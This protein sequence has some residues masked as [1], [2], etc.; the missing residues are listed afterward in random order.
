MIS[1]S[2][3][4]GSRLWSGLQR[5]LRLRDVMIFS[6][7]PLFV[8]LYLVA[9]AILDYSSIHQFDDSW[10]RPEKLNTYFFGRISAALDLPKMFALQRDLNPEK[11]DSGIIRLSVPSE[12]WNSWQRDPLALMGEWSKA[13]L[14]RHNGLIPVKLRKRGDNSVHWVTEKKS[15]TLRTPAS[16]LFKGERRLA[17]SG[18]TVLHSFSANALASEF[19]LLAPYTVVAPVFVNEK[20]YGVFR[21]LELIDESFLRRNNRLPGNIFRGDAAERGE[22][23]KG[24]PRGLVENPYIWDRV[25]KD[26]LPSAHADETLKTFLSDANGSTFADHLRFMSW[27]D[28]EE[29]SR[30][31]A[32]MLVV[33]DP[34]H[35]SAIHNNYWYQDPSTG[36]LHP[37]PWDLRM[38]I[39]EVVQ[40]R[41]Y[42]VSPLFRELLRNP[43]VLDRAL[44]VLHEKF[45][46]DR[47]LQAAERRV[48]DT[49]GRYREHFE[50]D[51]QREP[52]T[53]DVGKPNDVLQ[54]LRS[55][56]GL[57]NDW[58]K[59]SSVAFHADVQSVA[60]II[61][62]FEARGYTG[63]DLH[64]IAVE[65]DMKSARSVRLVADSNR[66]GIL[67]SSDQE[68]PGKW[69]VT[70]DG[71]QLIPANPPALLPGVDT[72]K[73]GIKAAP[74][75]YRFFLTHT[76][77]KGARSQ[78]SKVR[79]SLQNRLT[80]KPPTILDWKAG[81][82]VSAT[83]SWHPWQ[84]PT[85]S[86]V[87]HRLSG[88]IHLRQTLVIPPTD[89]LIIDPG[90]TVRLDAD[91]SILSY[92]KVNARGTQERPITILPAQEGKPWGSFA[93]QGD[94][95]SG[96]EFEHVRFRGGG[97]AFL[98][99]VE[100]K[101][102][103][104]IHRANRVLFRRC[105]L[106]DNVRSDDAM[107]AVHSNLNI[108]ECT[109]LRANSDAVDFDYSSGTIA[110]NR[111][112]ASGNDAIDLMRSGPRIIGNHITGSGDKG[113]SIG[114]GSYPLVFN[115][116]IARSNRGMEIKDG[117][118]PMIIQNTIVENEIGILQSAKNWRYGGGGWGKLVSSLVANNQTDIKSDKDSRL[119]RVADSVTVG[120][121]GRALSAG[122]GNPMTAEAAWVFAHYGIRP[123]S[124][125]SA[126]QIDGWTAIAPQAPQVLGTFVDDFAQVADG[127]VASGGV[128]S[129]E[130]RNQ[131][132]QA[133]FA[134]SRG[135]FSLNMDWNLMDPT[136]T[137][138]A[139]F[140]LAGK[141]LKT[142]GITAVA[143]DRESSR[144]I[145][146]VDG[147]A[148]YKFITL[149]LKPGRYSS[150]KIS[151]DP[152]ANTGRMHLHTYRL[153]AIPKAD[154]SS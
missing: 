141:N 144:A 41:H 147:L 151:A 110:N 121:D 33:G 137:Y 45:S 153:Y 115:N 58:F 114:E 27:V 86:P 154:L 1:F 67:D 83:P 125:T 22:V 108:E 133:T 25:A 96:S 37:I 82:A 64:G 119:T 31:V 105:E 26:H 76:N 116:Y 2:Q 122:A 6:A 143:T 94:G 77:S 49:Y 14:V 106:A 54:V 7:I 78:V 17:F 43:L 80:G 56:I 66:N 28:L 98:G 81:I 90:T 46:G 152:G 87:V 75:H 8:G 34:M 55:N 130:K 16:T 69:T 30:L 129:L 52:F 13:T 63:S 138:I 146:L 102:M 50:F 127:W 24:L 36:L 103:V 40:T 142:A 10:S 136:F 71:G 20:F 123:A 104:S 117:S 109:F 150:I 85:A 5:P 12:V 29:I 38:L 111:F 84:Y 88:D 118:E 79:V 42:R 97:G 57:L 11:I 23:Y 95:A 124:I 93:L 73:P 132:L 47:L 148:A 126:G 32:L 68:I 139:V 21:A 18:K 99:R 145:E 3:T 35:I 59:D 149:D 131:D 51:Q 48:R 113:I 53:P 120:A 89:T 72:N 112:E 61:L 15:F 101:G 65:G 9:A 74:L 62:D 92:G 44:H 140:E 134:R 100:Y 128:A 19:D 91:V 60:G 107:N 4:L 39:L 135:Q 70:P